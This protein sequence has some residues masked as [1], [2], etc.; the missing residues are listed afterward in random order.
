MAHIKNRLRGLLVAF[1]ALVAALAIVPGVAQ[2]EPW[3]T[4][5]T[6][7]GTGSIVLEFGEGELPNPADESTIKV[8][9]VADIRLKADGTNVTEIA[10]EGETTG[11]LYN[12]VVAWADSDTPTAAEAKAVVD[13][14]DTSATFTAATISAEGNTVTISNLPAGVYYIEVEDSETYAYQSMIAAVEPAR[15][16]NNTWVIGEEA[17][18]TETIPVKC[19]E[20][21]FNKTIKTDSTGEDKYYTVGDKIDYEITFNV[22]DNMA[23]FWIEDVLTGADFDSNSFKLNIDG[24]PH[25]V[26]SPLFTL[27]TTA[28][29]TFENVDA[30]FRFELTEAGIDAV[31][32]A[33]GSATLTYTAS[34]NDDATL[35]EGVYNVANSSEG[36]HKDVRLDVAGVQVKKYEKGSEGKLLEGAEFALYNSQN[37]E[38][39]RQT[40]DSDGMLTFDV[41]LD[42][43]E[44]YFIKET[45]APAGY[46]LDTNTY[47]VG[48]DGTVKLVA[49]NN[50][51]V[52]V[53]NIPSDYHEGIDLPQTGGAGTVAL[54]AAGVVIVAGA[55]A[56]IVRS[57]KEN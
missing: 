55:A 33:G 14:V 5:G 16:E 11:D 56:F 10:V 36:G 43:D 53:P 31:V 50:V 2:A 9:K 44:T 3:L 37:V 4:G 34:V 42:P 30:T 6:P 35:G 40:T 22:T 28:D 41:L 24:T 18:N 19:V 39:D 46:K 25:G 47:S 45:K 20:Q 21:G 7:T 12:A 15:G 51:V 57:R 49:F 29:D 17:N 52:E 13:L 1:V 32:N 54:T 8:Y 48:K 26:P 27:K 38:I 23:E